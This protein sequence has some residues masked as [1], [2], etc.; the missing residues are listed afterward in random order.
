MKT[1][2][3]PLL[4]LGKHLPVHIIAGIIFA[5]VFTMFGLQ[6]ALLGVGAA[7]SFWINTDTYW[8]IYGKGNPKDWRDPS[9]YYGAVIGLTAIFCVGLPLGAYFLMGKSLLFMLLTLT[10]V[11]L[12]S[13]FYAYGWGSAFDNQDED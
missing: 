11:N 7:Y 4:A 9:E 5:I 2:A 13:V 12:T 3:N 10:A 6:W 1:K 8:R